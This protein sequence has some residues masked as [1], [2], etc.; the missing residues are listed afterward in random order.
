MTILVTGG[1]GFIGSNLTRALLAR[2]EHVRVLARP[3]LSSKQAKGHAT[4]HGLEVERVPGDLNEPASVAALVDGANA[5][6]L[7][8]LQ[9]AA[10]GVQSDSHR[11]MAARV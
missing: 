3:I 4:L 2:G 11:A 5:P 9:R 6:A 7:P 1:A 10:R 8:T